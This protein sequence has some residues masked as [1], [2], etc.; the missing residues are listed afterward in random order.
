MRAIN[1]SPEQLREVCDNA[2][3][4]RDAA[5]KLGINI[6]TLLYKCD[7]HGITRPN[8]RLGQGRGWAKKTRPE[9]KKAD[10]S[11]PGLKRLSLEEYN[12]ARAREAA[13]QAEADRQA[14][15]EGRPVRQN[16]I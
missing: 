4:N 6:D 5:E 14:R 1:I 7:K 13:H 11:S 12:A 10:S 15:K 16:F 2:T 9:K 3:S 8:V